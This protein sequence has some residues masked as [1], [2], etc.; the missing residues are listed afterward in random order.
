MGDIQKLGLNVRVEAALTTRSSAGPPGPVILPIR[1][2]GRRPPLFL[3]HGVAGG[4]LDG[5][6]RLARHLGPDQ[7]VYAFRSRGLG[8]G[9][10]FTSLQAMAADYVRA[11]AEFAP[12]PYRLG[13]F[14][15][16]GNVAFEMACQLH[17]AGE[18]VTVTA[19]INS[20]PPNSRYDE[21]RWTPLHLAKFGFNLYHWT[22]SFVGW[23]PVRRRQFV[24]WKLRR[25][26]SRLRQGLR[27]KRASA[28][29]DPD[30]LVDLGLVSAERSPEDEVERRDAATRALVALAS[31][32]RAQRR[33]VVLAAMH[34][35]TATEVAQAES[36]PLGTAKSRIRLGMERLRA[37]LLVEEA[38]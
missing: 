22:R 27:G 17:D 15:F 14:C 30:D 28:P 13:G 4:M 1:A 20:S 18:R 2:A 32:P 7:P 25:L 34:G 5:Y 35:R 37:S 8:G 29:F 10:E 33:A 6:A 19:L 38:P 12:G 36:I 24:A 16:G 9:E 31:L 23:K 21:L 3:V 26:G 11:L